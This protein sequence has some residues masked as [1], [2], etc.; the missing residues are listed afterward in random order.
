[1]ITPNQFEA[2][3]LSGM[4]IR[5]EAS[6]V[7]AAASLMKLGPD[8]VVITSAELEA[9]PGKRLLSVQYRYLADSVV[10]GP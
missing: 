5:S 10:K 9:E 8:I 2:E 4:S 7:A 3:L 6:A 1:M